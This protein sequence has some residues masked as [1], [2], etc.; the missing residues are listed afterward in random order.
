MWHR[1]LTR[2]GTFIGVS[3]HRNKGGVRKTQ[4]RIWQKKIL[5]QWKEEKIWYLGCR[6]DNQGQNEHNNL[7]LTLA[8]RHRCSSGRPPQLTLPLE[9]DG[10]HVLP[11]RWLSHMTE[12]GWLG[13]SAGC[14]LTSHLQCRRFVPPPTLCVGG[15]THA[16]HCSVTFYTQLTDMQLR[17]MQKWQKRFASDSYCKHAFSW[18]A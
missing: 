10:R 4:N 2:K 14:T 18:G 6:P 13:N 1:D 16:P 11:S 12:G 7:D 15:F 3:F 9:M 17:K 8:V 5:Y